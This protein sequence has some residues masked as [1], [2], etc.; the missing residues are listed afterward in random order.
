MFFLILVFYTSF[1]IIFGILEGLFQVFWYPTSP[2]GRPCIEFQEL[3]EI[4]WEMYPFNS[5]KFFTFTCIHTL[6]LQKNGFPLETGF[7]PG[8]K[9]STSHFVHGRSCVL[10]VLS[11]SIDCEQKSFNFEGYT[12]NWGK[13]GD[14][15]LT[16]FLKTNVTKFAVIWLRRHQKARFLSMRSSKITATKKKE[17]RKRKNKEKERRRRKKSNG[18]TLGFCNSYFGDTQNWSWENT[19]YPILSIKILYTWN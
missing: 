2:P 13:S 6:P 7:L 19:L 16:T 18:C 11:E 8:F 3:L 15:H 9:F 4:F 10:Q 5:G 12:W 1:S 14:I 17:R